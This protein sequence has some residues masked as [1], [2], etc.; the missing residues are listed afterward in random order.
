MPAD[1]HAPRMGRPPRPQL[2]LLVVGPSIPTEFRPHGTKRPFPWA[3]QLLSGEREKRRYGGQGTR[4]GGPKI[5]CGNTILVCAV[6]F[7]HKCRQQGSRGS[8]LPRQTPQ[9]LSHA[10][11]AAGA[12]NTV[13]RGHLALKE[14]GNSE[15]TSRTTPGRSWEAQ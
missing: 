2:I 4:P 13:P 5:L 11:L 8:R 6:P 7:V 9:S 1:G 12:A 10:T 3:P 15:G 14:P